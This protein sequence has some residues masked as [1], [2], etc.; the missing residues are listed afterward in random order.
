M[1]GIIVIDKPSGF[2]SRD[3]VNKVSKI[4]GTKKIGHT[5][6]L[7]PLA[8]GVLVLCIG[9][10]TCLV[11][12][13][14]CDEKAYEASVKLG[15]KTDTLDVTGNVLEEKKCYVSKEKLEKALNSFKKTYMQEVPIY[16]A[17][18]VSG[19]RLYEYARKGEKVSLPKKEVTI[20]D[21]KL[22]NYDLF[23]YGFSCTVSKGTYIRSLIKDINDALGIIG[24]M[25]SLRRTRQG[26]FSINDAYTLE[27][28]EEGNY[29]IISLEEVLKDYYTID[30]DDEMYKKVKNGAILDDVYHKDLIVFKYH[31]KILAVYMKYEKEKGKIKPFKMF[32]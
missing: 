27:E 14:T 25:S 22:T 21:I 16:S 13:L 31:A 3:V 11:D 12:T 8:T 6:T 23:S 20:K 15:I 10:A 24:S 29:K 28:V 17:V 9:K 19:K 5:G 18:K 26:I 1:N 30:I 2:T 4:L 32:I 7:D